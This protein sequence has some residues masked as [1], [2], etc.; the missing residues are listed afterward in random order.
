V[1]LLVGMTT[2]GKLENL[3]IRLEPETREALAAAAVLDRRKL[4]DMAR[5]A[6]ADWLAERAARRAGERREGAAA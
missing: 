1:V 4:S 2:K 6:L 5:I 3:T